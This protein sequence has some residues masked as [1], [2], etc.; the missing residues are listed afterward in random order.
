[1][2]PA[3]NYQTLEELCDEVQRLAEIIKAQW[4]EISQLRALLKE[5]EE[6]TKNERT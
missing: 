5:Y 1:M 2:I 4:A 3:P 6:G